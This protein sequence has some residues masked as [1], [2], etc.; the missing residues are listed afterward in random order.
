ME[1]SRSPS[2]RTSIKG[3]PVGPTAMKEFRR[4]FLGFPSMNSNGSRA[5]IGDDNDCVSWVVKLV[6]RSDP[7]SVRVSN[8]VPVGATMVTVPG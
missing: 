3:S 1:A 2:S 4:D 8:V 7:L 5:T 6:S